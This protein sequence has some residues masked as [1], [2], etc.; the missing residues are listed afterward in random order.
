MGLL[1]F[2]G[3]ATIYKNT[4]GAF[5]AG[6]DFLTKEFSTLEG[7]TNKGDERAYFH[8][9]RQGD[10]WKVHRAVA[11][12]HM[13]VLMR[14]VSTGICWESMSF[15]ERLRSV[16]PEQTVQTGATQVAL[17]SVSGYSSMAAMIT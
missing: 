1:K 16:L 9:K 17:C 7:F 5:Y 15:G 12:L 13:Y 2:V 14:N 11:M 3:K 6:Q 10:I 4:K 8:F